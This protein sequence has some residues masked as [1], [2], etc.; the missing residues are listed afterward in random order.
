L[1]SLSWF[2][3]CENHSHAAACGMI[4]A[5]SHSFYSRRFLSSATAGGHCRADGL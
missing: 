5:L 2:H 1:F 4:S 3:R